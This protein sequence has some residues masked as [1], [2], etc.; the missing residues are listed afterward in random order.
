MKR[1]NKKHRNKDYKYVIRKILFNGFYFELIAYLIILSL[2]LFLSAYIN[3]SDL[4]KSNI[5]KI[6]C[7]F[8]VTFIV[9]FM[10]Y[11]LGYISARKEKGNN[12]FILCFRIYVLL[13]IIYI[14]TSLFYK[15]NM[16][17]FIFIEFLQQ[18]KN[19]VMRMHEQIFKWI[20][21]MN[22]NNIPSELYVLT[23]PFA[24]YLGSLKNKK[25]YIQNRA[26]RREKNGE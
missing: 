23:T 8:F 21:I 3:I 15:V 11:I 20:S 22:N 14:L 16:D 10:L 13:F 6:I 7:S 19:I 5:G 9:F 1:E 4:D 25:K 12:K 24:I 2:G 18:F 17:N 26:E